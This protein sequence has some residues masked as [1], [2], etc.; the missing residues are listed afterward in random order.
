MHHIHAITEWKCDGKTVSTHTHT[1][2]Q[3]KNKTL[4]RILS[5]RKQ[6]KSNEIETKILHE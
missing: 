6:E 5:I 4:H 1:H 3:K 2:K